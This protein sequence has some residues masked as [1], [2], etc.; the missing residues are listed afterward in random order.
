MHYT[1]FKGV[2]FEVNRVIG[3]KVSPAFFAF[4]AFPKGSRLPTENGSK[5]LDAQKIKRKSF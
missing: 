2:P 4:T 1:P 5:Q 3:Q